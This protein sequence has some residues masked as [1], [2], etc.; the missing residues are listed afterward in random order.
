M[1]TVGP[2]QKGRPPS[3]QRVL[4]DDK[5]LT[6]RE[7]FSLKDTHRQRVRARSTE[8]GELDDEFAVRRVWTDR[9]EPGV[10]SAEEWLVIRREADRKLNCSPSNAP[11]ESTVEQLAWPKCQRYSI[12]RAN[13]DSKTEIGW[14]EF[15]LAWQHRTRAKR[16]RIKHRHSPGLSP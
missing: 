1:P 7:V 9:D 5:P 2:G 12:E 15:H 6:V 4:S 13:E 16:S 10:P 8:R 11:A 14:D 3:R